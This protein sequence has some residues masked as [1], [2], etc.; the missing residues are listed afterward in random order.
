MLRHISIITS[1]LFATLLSTLVAAVPQAELLILSFNITPVFTGV[2]SFA[3]S[4]IPMSTGILGT[5][6]MVSIPKKGS[7]PGAPKGKDPNIIIWRTEDVQTMPPRDGKGIRI[8]GDIVLKTNANAIAIYAT[9]KSI[10]RFDAG[11]G[12]PDYKAF[13]NNLEFDHPGD[14]IELQ[15]FVA[16]NINHNLNAMSMRQGGKAKKVHG[17]PTE[18]L[19]FDIEEQDDDEGIKTSFK[20]K[21]IMRGPKSAVYE[22]TIPQ[23]DSGSGGSSL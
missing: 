12:E 5:Y 7:N 3:A 21:S 4:F 15:E 13:I 18:P 6:S 20:L 11:E 22:G 8:T 23:I 10:K 1:L 14:E 16:N 9:P 2:V 19:Q 17:T